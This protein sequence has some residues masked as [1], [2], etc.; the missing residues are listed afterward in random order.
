LPLKGLTGWLDRVER[1]ALLY[2]RSDG[3]C[4]QQVVRTLTMAEA[5]GRVSRTL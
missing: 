2:P 4:M 5:G 1:E 3:P